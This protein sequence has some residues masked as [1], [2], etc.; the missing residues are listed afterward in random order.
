MKTRI[1][2]VVPVFNDVRVGRALESILSQQHGHEM[3]IIVVNAGSTHE[4][5]EVL[6]R[7]LDKISVFINEPDE[8]IYDGMN[9]GIRR[10]TGEV[11]GI[12]NADDRYNDPL[13]LRDVADAFGRDQDVDACYG[14]Q[15]YTNEAGKTVRY[16]KA[17][18][19]RKAKWRLGWMPP[20]P[21]FFVRRRVYERYGAF[22]LRY[23]IAADYELMLRLML[24][25]N[26]DV[27][28][29][30]RVLLNMEPGGNSTKNIKRII[31]ANFE[32][33]RACWNHGLWDML[34][35]PML[36]PA[37]KIFQIIGRP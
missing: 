22:D 21:T 32:V 3:E 24:K 13:V 28:Y 5:L 35:V 2:I 37:R 7:Y 4:T 29:L 1:S 14:D 25:H 18:D 8:G 23:P 36:K 34:L 6:E 20:H 17:G 19:S 33:G 27:K 11:V 31:K 12:L 15:I 10:A 9:K 16:W 30:G 26:I